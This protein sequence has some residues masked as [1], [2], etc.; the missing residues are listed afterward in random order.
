MHAPAPSNGLGSHGHSDSHS[1][2]DSSEMI[3][4]APAITQD[5]RTAAPTHS[6]S[7]CDSYSHTRQGDW[8]VADSIGGG[9]MLYHSAVA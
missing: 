9:V 6:H 4:N 8:T 1:R 2:P 5:T 3:H 7:H